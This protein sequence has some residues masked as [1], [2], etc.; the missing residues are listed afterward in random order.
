MTSSR[1][2]GFPEFVYCPLCEAQTEV[3]VT[4]VL[5][6]TIPPFMPED[7]VLVGIL[8][9]RGHQCSQRDL[10]NRQIAD[11]AKAYESQRRP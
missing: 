2:S 1:S 3:P 8:R 5:S 10:Q 7:I 9:S 6:P 4:D 11:L